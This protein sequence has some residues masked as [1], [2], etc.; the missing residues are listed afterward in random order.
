MHCQRKKNVEKDSKFKS[1]RLFEYYYC[2]IHVFE[3][4]RQFL[5]VVHFCFSPLPC[6]WASPSASSAVLAESTR[7]TTEFANRED[8]VL[9]SL[10]SEAY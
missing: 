7:R 2:C 3:L 4:L 9:K 10:Q 1:A 8:V 5:N 6:T